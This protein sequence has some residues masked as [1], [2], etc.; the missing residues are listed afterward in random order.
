[1]CN[2]KEI[3]KAQEAV[4]QAHAGLAKAMRILRAKKQILKQL[5]KLKEENK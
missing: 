3:A 1:M 4:T 5:E 2:T